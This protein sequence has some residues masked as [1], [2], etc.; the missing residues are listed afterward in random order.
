M[1]EHLQIAIIGNGLSALLCIRALIDSGHTS[2]LALGVGLPSGRGVAYSEGNACL[3]NTPAKSVSLTANVLDFCEYAQATES[4]FIARGVYGDYI[5]NRLSQYLEYLV[6]VDG[7]SVSRSQSGFQITFTIGN[8][9]KSLTTD[10]L[11]IAT[12]N[13][14]P[15]VPHYLK[16]EQK[17]LSSIIT[18]PW[19]FSKLTEADK[20]ILIIGQGLT[21]CD[22]VWHLAHDRNRGILRQLT[23]ASRS[24]KWPKTHLRCLPQQLEYSVSDFVHLNS[25]YEILSWLRS[26]ANDAKDWRSV[27]NAIRPWVP[28]LWSRLSIFEQKRFFRL[29]SP[30]WNRLR[31]RAPYSL[32][33]TIQDAEAAGW[34]TVKTIA[35]IT[36]D[37]QWLQS[38]DKIVIATGTTNSVPLGLEH[39]G[40]EIHPNGEGLKVVDGY[41]VADGIYAIGH[42]LRGQYLETTGIPEIKNQAK[43]LVNQLLRDLGTA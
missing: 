13:Q 33:Q 5:V 3:L 8:V 35:G 15:K 29:I 9:T 12:G 43:S 18:N 21:S 2:V 34:L 38:F 39:L 22:W 19:E 4:D 30:I 1:Q 32:A 27:I 42:L 16:S 24:G 6:A 10:K 25:L 41:K 40:L 23:V 11:V 31:H 14:L 26:E 36:H 20:C 17:I 7:Y 37:G 28:V